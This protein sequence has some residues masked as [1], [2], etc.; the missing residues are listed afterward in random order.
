M[1][2]AERR[3]LAHRSTHSHGCEYLH[4]ERHL[5]DIYDDICEIYDDI[6]EIHDDIN[7]MYNDMNGGVI[8]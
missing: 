6:C 3:R 8:G 1:E 2:S 4:L 5:C 7:D